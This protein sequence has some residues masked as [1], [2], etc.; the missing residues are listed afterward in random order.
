MNHNM[1]NVNFNRNYFTSLCQKL[2]ND[3]R[4]ILSASTH[5]F[6]LVLHP[7]LVIA[8]IQQLA[9]TIIRVM[10]YFPMKAFRAIGHVIELQQGKEDQQADSKTPAVVIIV[11]PKKAVNTEDVQEAD[12]QQEDRRVEKRLMKRP[13]DAELLEQIV[14]QQG[15]EDLYF[16]RVKN[17]AARPE[18][19]IERSQYYASRSFG[20]SSNACGT[21]LYG[22][23]Y[24]FSDGFVDTDLTCET[25]DDELRESKDVNEFRLAL[26]EGYQKILQEENKLGMLYVLAFDPFEQDGKQFPGHSL[27]IQQFCPQGQNQKAVYRM[28]QSYLE[29]WSLQSFMDTQAAF[30]MLSQEEMDAFCLR[31]QEMKNKDKWDEDFDRNYQQ[32]FC[33]S[34]P[35]LHGLPLFIHCSE[36]NKTVSLMNF[37][38]TAIEYRTTLPK[39]KLVPLTTEQKTNLVFHDREQ[40][41]L[42]AYIENEAGEL[43]RHPLYPPVNHKR[44]DGCEGAYYTVYKQMYPTYV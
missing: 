19:L 5:L 31:L 20:D 18:D 35:E 24:A 33:A 10:V 37:H 9:L 27:V 39:R 30:L 34:H 3:S 41:Y 36:E 2:A 17:L 16:E 13:E 43:I 44:P 38:F 12:G 15:Y 26:D 7:S 22:V 29:Q 23:L 25:I 42:P 8:L 4:G 11:D 21:T 32:N 6:R 1:T 40:I 28:Y 14:E